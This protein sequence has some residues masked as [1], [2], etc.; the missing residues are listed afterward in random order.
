MTGIMGIKR[1]G[2]CHFAKLNPQMMAQDITKRIC[3]GAPPNV[4]LVPTGLKMVRP[5][6]SVSEEACALYRNKDEND[7]ARE[8]TAMDVAS[9]IRNAESETKQ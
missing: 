4:S 7:I 5:V 3:Y 6:V 8:V 1:C 9:Q 2:T